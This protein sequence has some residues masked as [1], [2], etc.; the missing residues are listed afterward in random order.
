MSAK[1]FVSL[2]MQLALAIAIFVGLIGLESWPS[3]QER[4]KRYHAQALS[5]ALVEFHKTQCYFLF[6]I[7]IAALVLDRQAYGN[8]SGRSSPPSLDILLSIP[9]S[10][11][12][13]VPIIFTLCC[14]SR[15]G[16]MS[17]HIISLSAISITLST[18]SLVT[19]YHWILRL[20]NRFG[21]DALSQSNGV[22]A[23][24]VGFPMAQLVCGS[25]G[26]N[27]IKPVHRSDIHLPLVWAVYASCIVWGLLCLG[28]HILDRPSQGMH[29]MRLLRAYLSRIQSVTLSGRSGLVLS[30]LS[31]SL[32][33]SLWILCFAYH[34]YL[35]NFFTRFS[36]V[37]PSWA[38]GQII[39]VTVWIPSITEFVYI[40][41]G[42]LIDPLYIYL[43]K[44]VKIEGPEEASKYRY[45]PG[46]QVFIINNHRRNS[47]A[48]LELFRRYLQNLYCQGATLKITLNRRSIPQ[49]ESHE[50][51]VKGLPLAFAYATVVCTMS[52]DRS[53]RYCQR[54][55]KQG[56]PGS[57][58][59]IRFSSF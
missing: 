34:I 54:F 7:E 50:Y 19:S 11:N 17:W 43:T 24:N 38:L 10:L 35:Y 4:I 55:A 36:L 22:G 20:T 31:Y 51:S 21:S 3:K 41:I 6:A 45:P 57:D 42:K 33:A 26:S 29:P 47:E 9:L 14:I 16:R 48:H 2:H 49:T 32:F 25:S 30:G 23:F 5:T 52:R 59:L 39:A 44:K 27:I 58:S 53:S 8:Q 13:I 56:V 46:L 18:L 40:E 1:V 28:K 37:S 15:Y 12:G